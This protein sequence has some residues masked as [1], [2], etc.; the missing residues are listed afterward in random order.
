MKIVALSE[1]SFT[2]DKSKVFIPFNKDVDDLQERAIGSLLVEVQPF[3]IVTGKDVILLDTGLGFT[4]ESTLQ[5]YENLLAN[6]ISP[7]DVTKVCLSHLHKDHA[8]GILF[9]NAMGIRQLSFPKATYFVTKKEFD[10]AM[11]EGKPSYDLEDFDFLGRSENLM[12]L[13]NDAG[14][15]GEQ[16]EYQ[17]TG[18][19]SPHH[20]VFWIRENGETVFFGGDVA[21]QLQQMKSRFV[22]KY[23]FDGKRSLELRSQWWQKGQSDHWTFLFYHDIKTPQVRH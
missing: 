19:H 11:Q 3:V 5:L 10:F 16:I 4:G 2:I 18:G 21:P 20:T 7:D 22:A 15:I 13:E 1:G 17:I 14:F 9:N 12:L 8:G 6:N 23:D